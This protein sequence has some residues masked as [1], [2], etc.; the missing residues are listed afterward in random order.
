ML[1]RKDFRDIATAVASA[2]IEHRPDLIVADQLVAA[3]SVLFS[4]DNPNFDEDKFDEACSQRWQGEQRRVFLEAEYRYVEE[5]INKAEA[6][7]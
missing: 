2:R 6:K 4:K 7:Q 5:E 3:L 1:T